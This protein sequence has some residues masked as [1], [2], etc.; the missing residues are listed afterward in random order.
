MFRSCSLR[1]S[2][3]GRGDFLLFE[4]IHVGGVHKCFAL[5]EHML[6]GDILFMGHGPN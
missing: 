6:N 3:D 5:V 4:G 1:T 2:D